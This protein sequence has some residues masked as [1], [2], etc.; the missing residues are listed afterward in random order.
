MRIFSSK[1][2][3]LIGHVLKNDIV[4]SLGRL[5]K[6]SMRCCNCHDNNYFGEGMTQ[7]TIR[8]SHLLNMTLCWVPYWHTV[9]NVTPFIPHSSI[10]GLP[11]TVPN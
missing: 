3:K 7:N 11:I 1:F 9:S 5:S 6:C 10:L 4:L 8:T 2:I